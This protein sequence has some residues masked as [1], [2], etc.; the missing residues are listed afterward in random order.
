[1]F[2]IGDTVS[3]KERWIIEITGAL[4]FLL[5]WWLVTDMLHLFSPSILPSPLSVVVSFG[6]LYWENSLIG[7]AGYSIKLNVL[8]LVEAVIFA[9]PLG[10]LIGLVPALRCFSERYL[11]VVRFLPLTAVVGLFIAWFGIETNMKVQFLAFSIFLF[12]LPEVI[13]KVDNVEKVYVDV[14]KTLGA[15][16]L[17]TIRRVYIPL[18]LARA[19][20]S[21]RVLA[22]LSWTYIVVAEMVNANGGGVGAL[23]YICARQARIDKVF[24]II[25]TILA[26]GYFQDKILIFFDRILFPHKYVKK[27]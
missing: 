5:A 27:G 17:Q 18:V 9:V 13:N 20:D 8:G 10:L 2:R 12:L 19:Y 3:Q 14:L 24:A 15:K 7:N 11:T 4:I 1:M 21:I 23:A 6:D 22:A 16:D 26:I 25:I